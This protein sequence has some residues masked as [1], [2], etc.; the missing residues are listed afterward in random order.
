[1]TETTDQPPTSTDS[2]PNALARTVLAIGAA[3]VTVLLTAAAFWLSYEHL[4]DTAVQHGL[5]DAARAW[6]WPATVDM[7]IVIGELLVLRGSLAR[8]VDGFAIALTALGSGGS[9]A[10][11]VA[12]TG[13]HHQ[14]L[15]YVVS[16][17]PPVAA[18]L[19][20]GALMRQLHAH[21]APAASPA[22]AVDVVHSMEPVLDAVEADP[23]ADDAPA[24][25][26]DAR[27]VT[28]LIPYEPGTPLQDAIVAA[29]AVFPDGASSAALA[30]ALADQHG[31]ETSPAYVRAALSR[32]RKQQAQRPAAEPQQGTGGYL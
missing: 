27:Q 7:F 4:H 2:P 19:A 1:M 6:A 9:I 26:D 10:L 18:L 21:L 32:H 11:N 29:A 8:R 12:G 16:A 20:F 28:P 13:A 23:D 15:D 17:V 3:A 24:A 25:D 14:L 5:Q 22:P 30:A 31:L